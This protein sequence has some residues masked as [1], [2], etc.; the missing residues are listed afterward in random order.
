MM[1]IDNISSEEMYFKYKE[2][3][4]LYDIGF[5]TVI[6]KDIYQEKINPNPEIKLTEEFYEGFGIKLI[7][8]DVNK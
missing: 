6:S 8:T 3:D 2:I 5:K 4:F 7:Q 1:F